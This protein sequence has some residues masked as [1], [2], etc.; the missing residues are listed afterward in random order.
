MRV[1]RRVVWAG[2]LCEAE[3]NQ[4]AWK[5]EGA[6]LLERA[7]ELGNPQAVPCRQF[8]QAERYSSAEEHRKTQWQAA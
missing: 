4:A 1:D 6:Y 2:I 3:A 8:L 7:D 5:R